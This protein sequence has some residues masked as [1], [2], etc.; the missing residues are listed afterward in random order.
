MTVMLPDRV[1]WN[2]PS[3]PGQDRGQRMRLFCV[4]AIDTRVFAKLRTGLD[5]K[6]LL[7]PVLTRELNSPVLGLTPVSCFSLG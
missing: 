2:T 6:L 7:L 3:S 5:L 4:S 1:L